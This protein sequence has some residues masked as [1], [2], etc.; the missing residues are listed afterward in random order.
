[1]VQTSLLLQVH[2]IIVRKSRFL[3]PVTRVKVAFMGLLFLYTNKAYWQILFEKL[4]AVLTVVTG[5]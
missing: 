2:S 5:I 4:I 3:A 1:M